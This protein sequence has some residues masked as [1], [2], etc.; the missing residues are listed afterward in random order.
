MADMLPGIS[1]AASSADTA[2]S[3]SSRATHNTATARR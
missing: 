3:A 2:D 1:Q